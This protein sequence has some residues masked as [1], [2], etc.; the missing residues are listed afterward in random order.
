MSYAIYHKELPARVVSYDDFC[1]SLK[2]GEWFD[3]PQTINFKGNSE[4]GKKIC[5]EGKL[6]TES[7]ERNNVLSRSL[8][9]GALPGQSD[10]GNTQRDEK[11]SNSE[12]GECSEARS[13]GI[14]E[15]QKKRGRPK[16]EIS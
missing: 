15:P 4:N 16:R 11:G 5:E 3:R 8:S 7:G 14:I 12:S 6:E 13:D 2:G 1:S 9:S 10:V